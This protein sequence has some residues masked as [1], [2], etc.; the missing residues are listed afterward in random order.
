MKIPIAWIALTTTL[1]LAAPDRALASEA[2]YC[3][4]SWVYPAH[5]ATNVPRNV[6]VLLFDPSLQ[7][8]TISLTD[9]YGKPID[10]Y[11]EPVPGGHGV[12]LVPTQLLDPHATYRVR[13]NNSQYPTEFTTGAAVDSQPPSLGSAK[14]TSSAVWGDC[15]LNYAA[16]VQASGSDDVTPSDQLMGRVEVTGPD[17]TKVTLFVGLS[18]VQGFFGK[19]GGDCIPGF[20]AANLEDTFSARVAVMDWAGNT[21]AFSPASSFKFA[22]GEPSSGGCCAAAGASG[23]MPATC[24]ALLLLWLC[25]RRRH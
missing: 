8:N 16:R 6:R 4:Y 23:V 9:Y 11:Q 18:Y 25:R 13:Y 12:W 24:L 21:S 1:A 22:Y 7:K 3:Q 17:A 10:A 14:V 19:M 15:P 5:D 2:C 20:A